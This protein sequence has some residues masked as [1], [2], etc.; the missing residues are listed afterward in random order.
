MKD[1]IIQENYGLKKENEQLKKELENIKNELEKT[2]KEFEEFKSKHSKTVSELRKALNIK[3]NNKTKP[4]KSGAQTGHKPYYRKIPERIDYIKCLNPRK[5]P[6]CNT[7]LGKT[8]EI[9]SR[10]V[11]YIKLLSKTETIK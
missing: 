3:Q 1:K 5:C 10:H 9:R 6:F 8:Q 11:T 2:K 7:K 4:K